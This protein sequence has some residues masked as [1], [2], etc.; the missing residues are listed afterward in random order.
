[1]SRIADVQSD[2]QRILQEAVTAQVSRILHDEE[3]DAV[4]GGAA[5]A[6]TNNLKQLSLAAHDYHTS[7]F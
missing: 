4:S 2:Q 6:C 3:I 5:A 7:T 1:M